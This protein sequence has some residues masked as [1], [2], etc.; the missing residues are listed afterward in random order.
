MSEAKYYTTGSLRPVN[1]AREE[2]FDPGFLSG[3]Y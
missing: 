2:Y 1:I 3:G